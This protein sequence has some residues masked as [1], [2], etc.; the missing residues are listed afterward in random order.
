VLEPRL[1]PQW[2]AREEAPLP[3]VFF[4]AKDITLS[5][6]CLFDPDKAEWD[7]NDLIADTTVPWTVDWL[8]C[9]EGWLATGRWHGGGRHAP[10][11]GAEAA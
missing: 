1:E 11:P 5:A 9:Y 2:R 8:A 4:D 10:R 3:H 6:L 7:P